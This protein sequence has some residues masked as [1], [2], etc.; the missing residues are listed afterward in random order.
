MYILEAKMETIGKIIDPLG[1][2]P[3]DASRRR[4]LLDKANKKYIDM[5]LEGTK[6]GYPMELLG[7][8][9]KAELLA[10]GAGG[11]PIGIPGIPL[12]P[13]PLAPREI[14]VS[15]QDIKT[16][17]D[18]A[19]K[20]EQTIND[21]DEAK[22]QFDENKHGSAYEESDDDE[23]L[24]SGGAGGGGY[25][26]VPLRVRPPPRYIREVLNP[27]YQTSNEAKKFARENPVA[28][29]N[30]IRD[31]VSQVS[32][33]FGVSA[34]KAITKSFSRNRVMTKAVLLVLNR[35][36][37]EVGTEVSGRRIE[38]LKREI[39]ERT[40]T[41]NA[42]LWND[43]LDAMQSNSNDVNIRR[44]PRVNTRNLTVARV[45]ANLNPID[46]KVQEGI[47]QA[48]VL[49]G[50]PNSVAAKTASRI[51]Q[52]VKALT[53]ELEGKFGSQ[54]IALDMANEYLKQLVEEIRD[55]LNEDRFTSRLN[56]HNIFSTILSIIFESKGIIPKA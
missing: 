19:K 52:R 7:F 26:R 33:V 45:G 15:N 53:K 37:I 42:L 20:I 22:Q 18:E 1:L 47:G 12:I 3:T 38:E 56:T 6:K 28:E 17:E 10:M 41:E 35:A 32:T 4:E 48:M 39:T 8:P 5:W 36:G 34:S 43:I 23:I 50:V 24:G 9:R 46:E 29:S 44:L 25:R 31:L 30:R 2:I 55:S 40:G 11:A 16:A 13:I 14:R 27:H 21:I 51:V 54:D 49:E